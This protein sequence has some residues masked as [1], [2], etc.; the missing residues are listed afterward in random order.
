MGSSF[1]GGL[2]AVATAATMHHGDGG[3]SSRISR[4]LNRTPSP[5]NDTIRSLTLV[6][7]GSSS[8]VIKRG[9]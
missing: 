3:A 1:T 7:P 6:G 9:I 8:L 4:V 2:P 5:R